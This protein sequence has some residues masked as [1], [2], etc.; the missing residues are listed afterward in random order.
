MASSSPDQLFQ[1][2]LQHHRFGR[3]VEAEGLYRQILAQQ[4]RHAD[5]LHLLGLCAH[6]AGRNDE[7]EDLI[8]RAIA[9]DPAS[10]DYH[11]NL[12]VV[13]A[14]L[15]RSAHA[16][17]AF[18]RAT[19]LRPDWADAHYNL[20]NALKD[21]GQPDEAIDSYRRAIVLRPDYAA[22]HNNLAALLEV[23]GKLPEAIIAYGRAA[24]LRPD[25]PEAHF[26]L[27]NA[28][29]GGGQFEAA[30]VS[31]QRALSLRPNWA[32]AYYNLGNALREQDRSDDA[33]AAYRRALELRPQFALAENNL[34]NVLKNQGELD[35]AIACFRRAMTYAHEPWIAGNL[36]YTLHFHAGYDQHE[37]YRE[38]VR[39]NEI[40]ARPLAASMLPHE[41]ERS[42]DKCLRVGY[43]SPDFRHHPVGLFLHP[44]IANHDHRQFQI[45][46]YCNSREADSVTAQIRGH[47]DLWREVSDLN[48]EQLAELIRRDRIDILVDLSLHNQG[49]RL[50]TFAR[51]PAPVQVT[52]LAYCSTTG[53]ETI[54]YRLTDPWFDPPDQ[55]DEG[56]Y[57]EQSVRLPHTYWCYQPPAHAPDVG[58]PAALSN[59][60]ITFGC[61][62][63]YAKVTR[64]TL[65]TWA[66]ILQEVPR[67]R[68]MIHSREGSHRGRARQLLSSLGID[69]HRFQFVGRMPSAAYFDQFQS[70]DIALDPF[71][72][73]GGTTS[74]DGLWMGVPVVTLAGDT[75]VSRNGVSILSNIGLPELIAGSTDEYIRIATDLARDLPRL[76]DL[77]A[78]MRQRMQTSP[79]MD[80][81]RFARNLEAAYRQMWV[82]YLHK[83]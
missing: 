62:N 40:Y 76:A 67:S 73:P 4:P 3:V 19:V 64:P 45:V 58:P 50:L 48:D 14:A 30:I 68:L 42:P 44:L 38:H 72:Y 56:R 39:W 5:A 37:I 31:Y 74:C 34:A 29:T 16:V 2:A 80:A 79:L 78:G 77:R 7:A 63:N 81:P 57:S 59:G 46:C 82:A 49:N 61:L 11:A 83:S 20:G 60:Y 33:V 22:A 28:L 10:A 25:S 9:L 52:Y 6:Q 55:P 71:P 75:A 65:E 21:A 12:G 32:E 13:L 53:L 66:H 36:L 24:E 15:K 26:L 18:Q 17:E 1:L 47:A 70:I 41:N 51:R 35:Q 8:R 23:T 43:V 54:D 69:P 27:G